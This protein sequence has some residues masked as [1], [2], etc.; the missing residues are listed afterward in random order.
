MGADD[1]IVIPLEKVD[2]VSVT[3][4][5]S[6]C[7]A[8]P[9]FPSFDSMNLD[10]DIDI[11]FDFDETDSEADEDALGEAGSM[12]MPQPI[13]VVGGKASPRYSKVAGADTIGA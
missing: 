7:T 6:A 12:L 3:V 8:P 10:V 2:C 13:D 11:D 5:R 4:P 9:S 1:I